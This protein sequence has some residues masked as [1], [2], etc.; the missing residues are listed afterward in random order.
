MLAAKTGEVMGLETEVMDLMTTLGDETNPDPASTRG[1]LAA[2][3][4]ELTAAMDRIGFADDPASLLGMIEAEQAK[5]TQLTADLADAN[6]RIAMLEGG[7]DDGS[8]HPDPR[9]L[10]RTASDAAATAATAAGA[11]ADAAEAAMANRATMQTGMANSIYDAMMARAAADTAMAEAAKALAAYNV[12]MMRA[13]LLPRPP[14]GRMPIPPR[15]WPRLPQ[16]DAET[17]QGRRC[18]GCGCGAEDRR[19]G[20]VRRH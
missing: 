6:G 16:T 2:K 9:W 1:M 18:R 4:D 5:V 12:A 17:A 7:T 11:A 19:H 13:M 14:R 3:I 20:Q 15:A 8:A 10:R